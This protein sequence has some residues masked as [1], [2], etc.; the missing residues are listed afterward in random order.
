MAERRCDA[1][2]SRRRADPG[3]AVT[4]RRPRDRPVVTSA[5]RPS[6][7]H[8]C[9]EVGEVH[10]CVGDRRAVVLGGDRAPAG[11]GPARNAP[12]KRP[13]P[14]YVPRTRCC[15]GP[16]G[17]PPSSTSRPA[18]RHRRR[19]S[20]RTTRPRCARADRRRRRGSTR[21]RPA[22]ELVGADHLHVVG[23]R[24]AR[25]RG[26]H[27]ARR[28]PVAAPTRSVTSLASAKRPS[29]ISSSIPGCATRQWA[30]STTSLLVARRN[31]A[32]PQVT[33]S[34][35][36]VRN[37]HGSSADPRAPPAPSTSRGARS[38]SV[39][40]STLAST[41]AEARGS[42][43]RTRRSRRRRAGS[44][45][46]SGRARARGCARPCRDRRRDVARA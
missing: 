17:P 40:S 15:R 36:V 6:S 26:R 8:A 9:V 39:T 38:V 35:S 28:S 7:R 27:E 10:V 43:V 11:A 1:H 19:G 21:S 3:E 34:R 12:A 29:T 13:T 44:A 33:A 18:W 23:E 2:S 45:A 37:L 14:L 20:G 41:W 31:P 30:S 42:G 25:A 22:G 32:R 4:D 24:H 5:A 46:R 16:V